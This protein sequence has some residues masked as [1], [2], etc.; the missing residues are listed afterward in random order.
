M[1]GTQIPPRLPITMPVRRV[2][3]QAAVGAL[4]DAARSLQVP[5]AQLTVQGYRAFRGGR[6]PTVPLPSDV[7]IVLLFGSWASACRE[8]AAPRRPDA[9][10]R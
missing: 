1:R 4:R 10:Q 9:V 6:L 7:T 3:R 8:A 5:A 2:T